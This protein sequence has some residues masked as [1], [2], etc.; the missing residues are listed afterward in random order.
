M[1]L[2]KN[3]LSAAGIRSMVPFLQTDNLLRLYLDDNNI[4]L[5]GFNVLSQA[6]RDSPIEY[7]SCCS[8]NL[9]SEGFNNLLR[10]LRDS[11]LEEL[12]CTNCDIES[13][14]IDNDYFP[15][16]LSRLRLRGNKIST[17]GC[18]GLAKLL[19]GG[20]STLTQLH[21]QNNKI[22]DD[23]VEILVNALQNN[24][25][26]ADLSLK[27]NNE[28]SIEG[29]KACLRLVNDIS[30]IKATLQSNRTLKFLDVK[31][32]YG[33]LT[34]VVKIQLEIYDSLEINHDYEDDLEVVGKE[35]VIQTQLH[36]G[37]RAKLADLLGVTQ[38]LYSDINSL[39]L[40]KV[41]ALVGQH[42]GQEELYVAL[43]S[44][45]AGVISTVNR[46]EC[47]QQRR[48]YLIAELAE[49][50]AELAAINELEGD[51]VRIESDES[52]SSKRRRK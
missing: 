10:K 34:P 32:E 16:H 13:I 38:S 29:M 18:R 40:P 21:L 7:L 28:I 42:H 41:L 50:D 33:L 26:L 25:S 45:I 9:Q 23:G 15:K 35:K 31:E 4:E 43:K 11:P 37:K 39:H 47:I 19:Q 2:Y 46:K 24:T 49:L 8:N 51:V 1:D 6:L 17:E 20:D 5:E 48:A 27:G 52:R 22:D 3:G 44:S 30:G 36:S 14:E 12:N